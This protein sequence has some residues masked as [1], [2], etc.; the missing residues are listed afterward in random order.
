MVTKKKFSRRE[1]LIGMGLVGAATAAC[2]CS[3]SALLGLWWLNASPSEP[4]STPIPLSTLQPTQIVPRIAKPPIVSRASWGGLPPNHAA[5]NE[6]GFYSE[7]NVNGW[8][9]YDGEIQDAYQ[10]VVMH[11]AAFYEADDLTTLIEIQR[12]HR[13]DR[14]WADVAYHY[15]VGQN[16]IIYEGR[17]LNVRG[18]H[19]RAYNTGSLGICLLGN[20][21][22]ESPTVAQLNS[23]LSLIKWV[24]EHL[25]LSHIA[26]HREFNLETQC[27]GN[28]LYVYMEQFVEASGLILGT[29]GY[30]PPDEASA[31]PCCT[32][33]T[34]I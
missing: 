20:F 19:V 30:I 25:A 21:M 33:D 12:V 6:T 22:S 14:G 18:T 1:I 5:R 24:S 27:P 9:I 15:F 11:H 17:D 3:G 8:R 10:T 13:D 2:A 7:D 16:G 34:V 31:C 28:N 26:S 32:C 29:G 23:T 4:A